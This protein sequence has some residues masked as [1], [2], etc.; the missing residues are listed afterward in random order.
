M[1]LIAERVKPTKV[2][3]KKCLL[4]KSLPPSFLPSILEYI[5]GGLLLSKNKMKTYYIEIGSDGSKNYDNFVVLASEFS[6]ALDKAG[7]YIEVEQ[8]K[9]ANKGM[10]F[11]IV[12]IRLEDEIREIKRFSG[13]IVQPSFEK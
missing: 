13:A 9:R 5:V 11:E 2:K 8:R 7:T 6:E 4:V 3:V 10:K 12:E 1:N